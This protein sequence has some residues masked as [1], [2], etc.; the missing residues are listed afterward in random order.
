[1]RPAVRRFA[2]SRA[3]SP[4]ASRSATAITRADPSDMY[5]VPLPGEIRGDPEAFLDLGRRGNAGVVFAVHEHD[6]RLER[7]GRRGPRAGV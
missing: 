3:A 4:R 1:M 7:V 6:A 2:S 5:D